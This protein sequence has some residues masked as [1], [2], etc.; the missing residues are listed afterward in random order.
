MA[1]D[2][3]CAAV[4]SRAHSMARTDAGDVRE[5]PEEAPGRATAEDRGGHLGF[6]AHE[7]RNPLSTAL[8]TAE[9]LARMSAAERGGARGEKLSAMCLRSIARVRQLVEDHLLTE[10]L[11]V[12]G[13]P[14]RIE[15]IGVGEALG[16]VLERR[17]ADAPAVAQDVEPTLGVDADRALLERVLETLVAVAGADGSAVKVFARA[18]P[19]EVA[20]V[21]SGKAVDPAALADPVKGSPSDPTGRALALPLARRAAGALGGLLAVAEGGWRLTL[22]RARTYTP[23]PSPAARP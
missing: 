17:P 6:V 7:I 14:L 8:W 15:A 19:D 3:G 10:R 4:G 13:I 9:L 20:V 11:D 22:P 12:G 1:G 18:T 21:V 23:R 16:A 5:G 2:L